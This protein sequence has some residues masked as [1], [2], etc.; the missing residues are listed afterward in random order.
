MTTKNFKVMT[1]DQA[2]AK[3]PRLVSF[4]QIEA[5]DDHDELT[6]YCDVQQSGIVD[7]VHIVE[8]YDVQRL[9][10]G[11]HGI[12]YIADEERCYHL[13]GAKRVAEFYAK[14]KDDS[15]TAVEVFAQHERKVVHRIAGPAGRN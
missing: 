11:E 14:T 12:V 10:M 1:M 13:D 4:F 5:G 3:W 15:M 6:V 7:I 9:R 8:R 2:R